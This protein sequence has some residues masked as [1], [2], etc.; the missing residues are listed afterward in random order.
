MTIALL[1]RH[2][3]GDYLPRLFLAPGGVAGARGTGEAPAGEF[4]GATPPRDTGTDGYG[5]AGPGDVEHD[6]LEP[7]RSASHARQPLHGRHTRAVAAR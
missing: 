5:D 1:R 3:M 2:E 6:R 4:R 7:Q